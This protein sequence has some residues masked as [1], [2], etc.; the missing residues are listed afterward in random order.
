MALNK[1]AKLY[2]RGE[3][4]RLDAL[5]RVGKDGISPELVNS[6]NQLLEAHELVK[7]RF[8]A[9]KE[10]RRALS[11]EVAAQT[12]AE[13]VDVIGHVAVIYRPARSPKPGALS[14]RVAALK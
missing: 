4:R 9:H 7:V 10:D 13:L 3:G 6:L 12:G 5:A 11:Q 2:L 14:E 1:Q 8:V